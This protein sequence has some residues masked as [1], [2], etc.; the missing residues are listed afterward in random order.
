MKEL[1]PSGGGAALPPGSANVTVRAARETSQVSLFPINQIMPQY[2]LATNF[3]LI[4]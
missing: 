1:G 2:K 3:R 4:T